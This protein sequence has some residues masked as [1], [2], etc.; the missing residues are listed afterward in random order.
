MVS[1]MDTLFLLPPV[2]ESSMDVAVEVWYVHRTSYGS[3][4]CSHPRSGVDLRHA[5]RFQ[6]VDLFHVKTIWL[7]RL[8]NT[9]R[10]QLEKYL[11]FH[12]CLLVREIARKRA[13]Q[14]IDEIASHR[15]RQ[16]VFKD[17]WNVCHNRR[18]ME[19][20]PRRLGG[21]VAL[22]FILLTHAYAAA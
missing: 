13:V 17:V 8:S 2:L 1:V 20:A 6:Y 21:H 19:V 16:F 7:I 22:L 15:G 4:G 14:D 18:E 3:A 10:L 11:L 12:L 9:R 5:S